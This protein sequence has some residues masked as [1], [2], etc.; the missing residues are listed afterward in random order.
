MGFVHEGELPLGLALVT[1][2]VDGKP[3]SLEVDVRWSKQIAA[4]WY[5]SGGLFVGSRYTQEAIDRIREQ[6][7]FANFEEAG[8]Q[9]V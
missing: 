9:V 4:K 5:C 7:V 2:T 8:I 1:F 3:E 6:H